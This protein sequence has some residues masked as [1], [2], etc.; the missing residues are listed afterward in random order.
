MVKPSNPPIKPVHPAGVTPYKRP[1]DQRP[2]RADDH[3]TLF[4]GSTVAH[5]MSV[6]GLGH[7]HAAGDRKGAVRLW[8]EITGNLPSPNDSDYD[9]PRK[10]DLRRG[11]AMA[12]GAACR[13][14]GVGGRCL[15]VL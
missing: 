15:M 9:G 11:C 14:S 8:D 1:L 6:D 4:E 7:Q 12:E 10:P 13:L 2:V 5:S 3:R